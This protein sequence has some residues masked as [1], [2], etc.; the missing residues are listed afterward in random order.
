MSQLPRAEPLH[1][2]TLGGRG[3]CKG[4]SGSHYHSITWSHVHN[5]PEPRVPSCS[6]PSS[7]D[8][9]RRQDLH[10]PWFP[11]PLFSEILLWAGT[12]DRTC[13]CPIAYL[14]P[15]LTAGWQLPVLGK[16]CY[17]GGGVGCETLPR[18][19][20]LPVSRLQVSSLAVAPRKA[21]CI[22]HL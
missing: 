22:G 18:Q 16:H 8:G 4:S 20:P 21:R 10:D 12:S 13:H 14:G 2:D 19:F 9:T 1:L 5:P 17:P 6:M 15:Y 11:N 7:E 3:R